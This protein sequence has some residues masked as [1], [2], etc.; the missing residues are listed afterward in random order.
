M[1]FQV[2]LEDQSSI[3]IFIFLQ[4]TSY[5]SPCKA[6]VRTIGLAADVRLSQPASMKSFV[7]FVQVLNILVSSMRL[8]NLLGVDDRIIYDSFS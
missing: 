7:Q 6:L 5:A 2:P 8:I 4:D 3:P 1:A